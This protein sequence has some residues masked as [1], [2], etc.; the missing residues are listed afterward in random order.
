[1]VFNVHPVLETPV[2]Q[3]SM[4]L[5]GAPVDFEVFDFKTG[6]EFEQQHPVD[7]NKRVVWHFSADGHRHA[8]ECRLKPSVPCESGTAS[9]ERMEAIEFDSGRTILAI[10]AGWDF[11]ENEK[12]PHGEW[13]Y[14]VEA[15]DEG[16]RFGFDEM[17][18]SRDVVIGLAW[19]TDYLHA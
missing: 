10:A 3:V 12:H 19:L 1:M 8:L 9:G 5:D 14:T 18:R 15:F 17:S 4:V 16:L 11:E 7:A 6:S 13:D 2:G